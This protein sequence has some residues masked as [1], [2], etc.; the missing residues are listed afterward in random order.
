MRPAT[1]TTLIVLLLASVATSAQDRPRRVAP[2]GQD[3]DAPLELRADLVTLTVSVTNAGGQPVSGLRPEAFRVLE[4][5]VP[6]RIEFFEAVNEPYSLLLLLDTSG[7]TI[8][9][10]DRM[11]S[12][13]SEFVGGLSQQDRLGIGTFSRGIQFPDEL[14]SNRRILS[15]HIAELGPTRPANPRAHRFDENTGTSFYD[16]LIL[17]LNDSPLSADASA[18]RRAI[19]VF[20]DC[21][22]STSTYEFDDVRLAAEKSG[23]SIY[24]VLFDTQAFSDRLLTQPD[25]GENRINFSKSQLHRFYDTFAADSPDRGR[26]PRSY[27]T[28]ERLEINRSLYELARQQAA[29]ITQRTGGRLYPVSSLADAGAAYRAI[30]AELRTRYSIG[31]YPTNERHDGTWRKLTVEVPKAI[32]AVV[33][34]RPGYWAQKD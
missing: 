9:D 8:N 22:D 25:E 32:D 17:A 30:A 6:Q 31:Y 7:S 1:I 29:E 26:D 19:I 11:R 28:L 3:P 27:S 13:A 20:S 23:V 4:D 18:R 2:D 10:I 24:V 5:G 21:V 15:G 12:S 14:T 34:A 33:V 16:A